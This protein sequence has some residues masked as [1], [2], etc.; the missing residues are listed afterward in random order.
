MHGISRSSALLVRFIFLEIVSTVALS[1]EPWSKTTI[2]N[3]LRL[4]E[5]R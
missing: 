3:I 1:T 5:N 2:P 4:S